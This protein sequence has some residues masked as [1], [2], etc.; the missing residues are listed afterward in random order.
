MAV[1]IFPL[2]SYFIDMTLPP[3]QPFI[4]AVLRATLSQNPTQRLPKI[5]SPQVSCLWFW[6]HDTAFV[7]YLLLVRYRQVYSI[8]HFVQIALR[9]QALHNTYKYKIFL[10]Y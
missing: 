1:S 6:N 2:F 4:P 3:S 5:F 7:L 8:L 9:Y 10:E